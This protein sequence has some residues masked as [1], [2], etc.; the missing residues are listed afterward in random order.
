MSPAVIEN[1]TIISAA[2]VSGTTVGTAI[3][4]RAGSGGT[5][6]VAWDGRTSAGGVAP[7]GTY[8]LTL[9]AHDDAGNKVVRSWNV[10]LDTTAAT[11][12][13][14]AT[15]ARFSPNGDG[16]ADTTRLAWSSSERITGSAR[17][18]RG[19]TLIR[20]WSI[21]NLASGA[22]TWNG[23]DAAG[24]AV[25][26]GTYSFRVAGR[27]AAGVATGRNITL[28]VDR[29]LSTVRW[30][31]SFHPQD[32][33]ALMP[34]SRL[35]FT[36]KRSASV[37]VAI[38][39]GSTLIRTVWTNRALAAGSYGWT[40]DGRDAARAVVPRGAYQA[41]VSVTTS[42]GTTVIGRTVLADAFAVSRSA[43]TVRAGQTLT[44][45]L[46]TTEPLR[47]SP[48]VTLSQP[49][50]AAVTRTATSLGSG[51]YRVTFTI[52]SGPAGTAA[53][54][55]AARDTANGLNVSTSSVTIR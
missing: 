46:V 54:R 51:R 44:L 13:S 19:T 53:I 40:W 5:A 6:S 29:T 11:L 3:A 8:R 50:R 20:S 1:T 10:R 31:R 22:I 39:S 23:I 14:S 12:A 55:I 2:P 16:A 27:D 18:Y 17:I 38:Y 32:G 24:R 47:A 34:N 30:S 4:T 33:D 25:A 26:D 45:T 42:L 21:A 35:T 7:D 15:P 43:T 49:G 28:V 48:G 37:S 52:A 9:A 41:R 36:L